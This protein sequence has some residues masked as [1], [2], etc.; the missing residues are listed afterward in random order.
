MKPKYEFC[1]MQLLVTAATR[2]ELELFDDIKQYAD[3][4][5]T[6]VGVPATIYHLQKR[7]LKKQYDLVLQAGIAGFFNPAL[8]LGEV[9][10]VKEDAFADI[11]I[12]ESSAFTSIYNTV[13]AD[14]DAFP[15]NN[16]WLVNQNDIIHQLNMPLVKAVTINTISDSEIQK[17][18]LLQHFSPDIETMEGAGMHFVC[19]H[20]NVPFLQL[21]SISNEVGV[22]DKSKWKM[23]EAIINLNEEL[24]KLVKLVK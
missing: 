5:I 14:K 16:G 2:A 23:K 9:V 19:L 17:Q 4:E 1:Q 7:L 15:F 11:G 6:G 8:N 22:R 13:F 12:R 10:V 18:Q 24:I 3:I 21:R 20:E